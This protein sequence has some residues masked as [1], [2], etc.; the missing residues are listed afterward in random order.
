M[1]AMDDADE[2]D[3]GDRIRHRAGS[4]ESGGVAFFEVIE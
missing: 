1:V 4:C 2:C 3:G